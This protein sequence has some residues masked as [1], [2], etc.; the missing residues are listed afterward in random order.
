MIPYNPAF[1]F[2]E[3]IVKEDAAFRRAFE[4]LALA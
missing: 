4:R 2:D 3:R 1:A